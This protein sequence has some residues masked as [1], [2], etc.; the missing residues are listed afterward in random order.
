[1]GAARPVMV[2]DVARLMSSVPEMATLLN[3]L[4]PELVTFPVKLAESVPL[5]V[6]LL[7]DEEPLE[8][9]TLPVR[10]PV[11]PE[12]ADTLVKAPLEGV[13]P[14]I[15]VLLIVPPAIVTEDPRVAAPEAVSVVKLPAAAVVAPIG[16]LL[17]AELVIAN[18]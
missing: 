10:L 16:V 1:M 12:L 4:V 5:T 17:I 11:N 6:T 13:V 2:A 7:N 14:P 3:E 18:D 8:A 15:V 9:V